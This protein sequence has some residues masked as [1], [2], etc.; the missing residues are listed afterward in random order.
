MQCKEARLMVSPLVD[1]ELSDGQ[2]QVVADHVSGCARCSALAADYRALRPALIEAGYHR[3][4]PDLAARIRVRL[5]EEAAAQDTRSDERRPRWHGYARQAAAVL[6]ASMF[7]ALAAWHLTRTQFDHSSIEHDVLTAHV[8]SLLQDR[9]TQVASSDRHEVK[10][11]FTG[12]LDFS[13]NV[14]DLTEQGF[15]LI[16]G[17][18]DVVGGRRIAS[19]VY[20]R[21][22]HVINVFVWPASQQI[23]VPPRQLSRNGYNGIAWTADGIVYWAVS[24]L[25]PTELEQFQKLL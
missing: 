25:N 21:R 7:S 18:L 17:R 16:G 20:R 13:P 5:V 23:S 12:K 14:K 9:P 10:P 15:P 24:D 8:R 2:R 11:W 3:A 19:I 6:V 1:G 4:A 22:L